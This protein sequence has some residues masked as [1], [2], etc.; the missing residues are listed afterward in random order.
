[1][2]F[3][4]GESMKIIYIIIVLLAT[5]IGSSSGLGGGV[6]IKPCLDFLA[7][8]DIANISFIS[9][10]A[11]FSMSLY[12]TYRHFRMGTEIKYKIVLFISLGSMLGGKLGNA[13]FNVLLKL[14]GSV[15]LQ[16]AQSLIMVMLLLLVMV[17]VKYKVQIKTKQGPIMSIVVGLCLGFIS[18]FIGIGGGPINVAAYMILYGV[19]IK[20]ASVLSLATILFAQSSNLMTTQINGGFIR[21]DVKIL[22]LV[23]P[24][25]LVG[26]SIGTKLN[27]VLK[28]SSIQSIFMGTLIF[29]IILNTYNFFIT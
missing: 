26:A 20:E 18:A 28:E 24:S 12:S 3:I 16:K 4:E 22:K 5:I 10:C 14:I 2:I 9:S 27:K 17:S 15:T 8:H 19:D 1:M 7:Y 25:A 29:L 11:V 23:I 13:A 21:F 6:I